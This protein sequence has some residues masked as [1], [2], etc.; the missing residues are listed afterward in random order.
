V[1]ACSAAVV[2][3]VVG[4]LRLPLDRLPLLAPIAIASAGAGLT[5]LSIRARERAERPDV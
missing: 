2:L 1:L 4:V 3:V 5:L